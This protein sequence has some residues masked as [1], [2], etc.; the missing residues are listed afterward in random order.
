MPRPAH[1]WEDMRQDS[2]TLQ[3]KVL[4]LR[5]ELHRQR[6]IRALNERTHATFRDRSLRAEALVAEMRADL[7]SLK[8]RLGDE[9]GDL[10]IDREKAEGLLASH[11]KAQD[12]AGLDDSD[13][14]PPKVSSS[15]A[16]CVWFLIYFSPLLTLLARSQRTRR[17]LREAVQPPTLKTTRRRRANSSDLDGMAAS[18]ETDQY[19]DSMFEE[20]MAEGDNVNS[21]EEDIDGRR[22]TKRARHAP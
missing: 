7:K 13:A 18:G 3:S 19:E 5:N 15:L 1:T 2:Y 21:S 17:A 9:V 8:D 16:V 4:H 22:A 12:N 20:R 6:R 11:Y 14:A 10:G